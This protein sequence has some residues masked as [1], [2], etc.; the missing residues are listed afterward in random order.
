MMKSIAS[1]RLALHSR[2]SFR[3]DKNGLVGHVS[4]GPGK[5]M[6]LLDLCDSLCSF[7]NIGPIRP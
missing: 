4:F 2:D 1:D 7:I 3:P 6:G 5:P